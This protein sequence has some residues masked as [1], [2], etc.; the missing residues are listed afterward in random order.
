MVQ[1]SGFKGPGCELR[2]ARYGL[3]D[4][5]ISD[6]A[7]RQNRPRPRPRRRPR[8]RFKKNNEF[9]PFDYEDEDDDDD[10][11]SKTEFLNTKNV[12]CHLFSDFCPLT[13]DTIFRGLEVR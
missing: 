12:I 7:R 11:L 9:M 10:D 13:P 4:Y 3:R 1:G 8:S 2:G 5:S 6:I